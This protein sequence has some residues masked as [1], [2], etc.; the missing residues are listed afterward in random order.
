[1]LEEYL[2]HSKSNNPVS[3]LCCIFASVLHKKV[4]AEVKARAKIFWVTVNPH[5]NVSVPEFVSRVEKVL[6]RSFVSNCEYA[7]EQRGKTESEVGKGLHVHI[8]FD[9]PASM[10]PSQ[11]QTRLYNSFKDMCGNKKHIDVRVYPATFRSDKHEYL[12]GS[13]DDPAKLSSVLVND[14]FRKKFN[15]KDIYVI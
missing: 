12:S 4:E 2:K 1:M 15:L 13:K 8:M 3:G 7:F 5:D 9:K 10:S 14:A 6:Q 11:L